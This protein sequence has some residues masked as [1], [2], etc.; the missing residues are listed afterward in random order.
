MKPLS[1][2]VHLAHSYVDEVARDQCVR[3]GACG[4]F[5]RKNSCVTTGNAEFLWMWFSSC[6]S[7]LQN[8]LR[9][10]CCALKPREWDK[11]G[12]APLPSSSACPGVL[13]TVSC[14]SFPVLLR[15]VIAL[16]VGETP[17]TIRYWC[18]QCKTC[19]F[20]LLFE[21]I[22]KGCTMSLVQD[23]HWERNLCPGGANLS[24]P[25]NHK[26]F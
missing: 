18:Q 23:Y 19:L 10:H 25:F 2:P 4:G 22:F 5:A 15:P 11:K 21:I 13:F 6:Q 26:S 24:L 16:D 14:F 17:D 8:C 3:W 7:Q 20:W 12:L 9:L 1:A